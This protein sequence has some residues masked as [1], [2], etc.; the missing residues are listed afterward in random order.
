MKYFSVIPCSKNA[1]RP[2]SRA[3]RCRSWMKRTKTLRQRRRLRVQYQES[4][5]AKKSKKW[6]FRLN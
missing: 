3:T 1:E 5:L 6:K 2:K 4:M